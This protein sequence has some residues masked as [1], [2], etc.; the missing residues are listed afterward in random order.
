[1]WA[2]EKKWYSD[3]FNLVFCPSTG[4]GQWLSM[5]GDVFMG[6]PGYGAT[7]MGWQ[8]PFSGANLTE[9][10]LYVEPSCVSWRRTWERGVSQN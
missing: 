7:L 2:Y 5:E 4:V 8:D 6:K 9:G 3:V 1:M 10:R